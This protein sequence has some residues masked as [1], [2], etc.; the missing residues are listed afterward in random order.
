MIWCTRAR[1]AYSPLPAQ[2]HGR[3]VGARV[4]GG[5]VQKVD[6][7]ALGATASAAASTLELE[8]RATGAPELG[9]AR[10]VS[11]NGRL[12][13][14]ASDPSL[15]LAFGPTSEDENSAAELWLESRLG[16]DVTRGR[17]SFDFGAE[18][19]GGAPVLA[20]FERGIGM[21]IGGGGYS[22][23][24]PALDEGAWHAQVRLGAPASG[25]LFGTL[26]DAL[27]AFASGSQSSGVITIMDSATHR[28]SGDFRLAAHRQLVVRAEREHWPHLLPEQGNALKVASSGAENARLELRGLLLDGGL[29]LGAGVL[30]DLVLLHTTLV[31]GRGLDE[32]GKPR[33]PDAASLVV[34]AGNPTLRVRLEA[35]ITG[36][37]AVHP[38]VDSLTLSDCIVD[39]TSDGVSVA[40]DAAGSDDAPPLTVTRC[41]MFGATRALGVDLASDSIFFGAL[42]LRRTQS[43]CLR[44][45]WLPL[46]SRAPAPYRCQP[47]LALETATGE[48]AAALEQRLAPVFASAR[49]G[50]PAYA[51]LAVD[52]PRE[53]R[54]GASSGSEMGA[55]SALLQPQR[56]A[57]LRLRLQ[58]HLPRG[59]EASLA[60]L[61]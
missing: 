28:V 52:C 6:V 1:A 61:T 15:P 30:E 51:E 42:A 59:L 58:E 49:Y 22:W 45:C 41:T 57:N 43:G 4:N 36:P 20:D 10:V 26:D 13:A 12:Y 44:F 9:A 29:E 37:L 39:R 35:C 32:T 14:L 18:P 34:P 16:I 7:S 17:I 3:S 11:A 54:E 33:F 27:Q 50:E 21:R 5:P 55:F 60:F 47:Q 40:G 56:E 23:A 25:S 53:V 48:S 31:P 38:D 46:A 19:R 24:E 8:L 2:P